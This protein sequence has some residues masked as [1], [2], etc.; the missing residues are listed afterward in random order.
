MIFK[1]CLLFVI[2]I[3]LAFGGIGGTISVNGSTLPPSGGD[4]DTAS[5]RFFGEAARSLQEPAKDDESYISSIKLTI[6]KNIMVVDGE[7]IP[8]PSPYMANGVEMLPVADIAKALGAEVYVNDAIGEI[9]VVDGDEVTVLDTPPN[10]KDYMRYGIAEV[11]DVLTL[12]YAV[13]GEDILLTRP[14]QSKMLLVHMHPGKTLS[15]TRGATGFVTDGNGNYVLKYDSISQTKDAYDAIVALP[16]CQNIAPNLIVFLFDDPGKIEI[17]PFT[18]PTPS[19]GTERIHADLMKE[20]L[21]NTGKTGTDIIVAVVDT[22][23]QVD[24]PHLAPRLIAGRDFSGSEAGGTGNMSDAWGHGTHIAGTVVDCTPDNVKIMPVKVFTD[25]GESA[26]Y[27]NIS[28]AIMWAADHSAKVINIS[29]GATYFVDNQTWDWFYRGSCDYAVS[30]GVTVVAAA[31]NDNIDIK[32]VSP[33]RLENVITVAATSK[34]D[35]RALFPSV[36]NPNGA[37]NFGDAVDICAPG[38]QINSSWINSTYYPNSGTS[39][40]TPHVSAAV[41]MLSLYNPTLKP[42]GLKAAARS[43]SADLGE[44]GW[45]KYFGWGILDFSLFHSGVSVSGMVGTYNPG[46]KTT[47]KLLRDGKVEAETIIEEAPGFGQVLQPF[48]LEHIEPGTYSLLITK[49]SHLNFTITG[50]TVG[51]D[52]LNL[53]ENPDPNISV[54]RLP[55]GDINDDGFI[56]SSDITILIIPENYD[57][58]VTEPGVNKNADLVGAGWVNS[59]SISVVILPYNYDRTHVVYPY[60]S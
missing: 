13:E 53:T 31:G 21:A 33:A 7:Q 15:D 42:D 41:A 43:I 22:G 35:Q 28:D 32:Y 47:I 14:F 50:I 20:Y 29:S 16:D 5:I 59:S 19:W 12:D 26:T 38:V 60:V 44:P 40:A 10:A 56:N 36:S 17:K 23:V 52:N 45:D 6:N 2:T 34:T 49:K 25:T 57:K 54:I 37:S 24:H 58:K 1:K 18:L 8:V 30:K 51:S 55:C 3:A 46:N 9:T 11:S 39:T 48:T 4:V 27:A